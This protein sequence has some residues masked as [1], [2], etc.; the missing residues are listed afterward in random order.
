M[1]SQLP[2]RRATA[3][4]LVLLLLALIL[5]ASF[6]PASVAAAKKQQAPASD[7]AAAASAE[8]EASL[9]EADQAHSSAPAVSSDETPPTHPPSYALHAD[10]HSTRAPPQQPLAPD[11]PSIAPVEPTAEPPSEDDHKSGNKDHEPPQPAKG[12]KAR[13]APPAE[14]LAKPP[15]ASADAKNGGEKNQ[16]QPSANP[17][18]RIIEG[19]DPHN[20]PIPPR[21]LNPASY[22]FPTEQTKPQSPQQ[23]QQQQPPQQQPSSPS[24][25]PRVHEHDPLIHVTP[26]PSGGWRAAD[27]RNRAEREQAHKEEAARRNSTG[28]DGEEDSEVDSQPIPASSMN[29][30]ED[31]KQKKQIKLPGS[32][33]YVSPHGPSAAARRNNSKW[34][35][36]PA[37]HGPVPKIDPATYKPAAAPQYW[38]PDAAH[39]QLLEERHRKLHA[40]HSKRRGSH[41]ARTTRLAAL[42]P[43][44][45]LVD[46]RDNMLYVDGAPFWIQGICYSPVPIGESVS[47]TPKGDYFTPDYAYIWQ[48]D[49]PL[50]RA[51]GATTLRIYGWAANADHT[52][53]LDAVHAAGLKVLVTFYLGDAEQNPVSTQDQRNQLIINFV[54]QVNKYRDHPGVLMWSFGNELNGAW[55]GFAKQFSDSFGCWWQAGCAGYSDTNSDC[56][57]QSSCMYYQL[58][59]WINAAC[60]AAKM[61]TT[62]PIISGFADVDY[63]VGPTPWLDKVARFNYVLPDMDAW[64][65]QLYRGWTFGG[66]FG[67]YRGESNKPMLVTEFGVDAY[68]DPCGWPERNQGGCFNMVGEPAGGADD[69]GHFWGC[70]DGGECAKP[71]VTAQ[72]EWDV[73]LAQ[74]LMNQYVDRGGILWGGFLMAW[75]DEF[76]KGGGTQDLCAFP[77]KTWDADWCRGP[78]IQLYKPGGGAMCS[79]RAHFTCPNFDTNYH[80]LCGYWLA[81]TP[82]NYVNEEWFGI[83]S[84]IP[85]GL[86]KVNPDGVDGG[87]HLD[88]FYV[89]PA[90]INMMQ[91]WSGNWEVDTSHTTCAALRPCWACAISHSME[92][93][94]DGA[95]ALECEIRS[96]AVGPGSSVRAAREQ[97]GLSLL[98][99]QSESSAGFLRQ[100]GLPIGVAVVIL[101]AGTVGSLMLWRQHSRRQ[102][103]AGEPLL[104]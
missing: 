86:H 53:F 68:N 13:T 46:I 42:D 49:L 97:Q 21:G 84:P 2:L 1:A 31:L 41:A 102:E 22:N 10:V 11:A 40:K 32:N 50:I 24:S 48:R 36:P 27:L 15:A 93:L 90:F 47:F 100:Y 80:D 29:L 38:T 83:T 66:Y 17:G 87:Y 30:N 20:L 72:S 60:R 94:N 103:Q 65:V 76:W 59:S 58:F 75:T 12:K 64:A 19:D 62:R 7:D 99:G 63:M 70:A 3:P 91:L 96:A 18:D 78:G 71:G 101:L 16:Q 8:G 4:L 45:K 81:A 25:S 54:E 52:M 14:V 98:R 73:R 43:G 51:M 39:M 44:T 35:D 77:C 69:N 74:E 57:W 89:R 34:F 37:L 56:H 6:I 33:S 88:S 9:G 26:P 82:D 28:A 5:C 55:N 104:R 67:M 85:C 23:D 92:D 61:V 95:C 79:W